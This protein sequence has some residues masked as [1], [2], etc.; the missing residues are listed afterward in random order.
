MKLWSFIRILFE[1]SW[2]VAGRGANAAADVAA[3]WSPQS[4]N[5][6]VGQFARYLVRGGYDSREEV[7]NSVRDYATDGKP[8]SFDAEQIVDAEIAL[9][10][11]DEATWPALTDFDRLQKAIVA[12]EGNGI[13]TRQN[14]TCCQTCGHAEIGEEIERFELAGNH[15][16]GYAFFHQQATESAVDGRDINFAYGTVGDQHSAVEIAK[17]VADS[18]RAAGLRVKWN[19]KDTMCVMVGM[20]W[21][22]RWTGH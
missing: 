22:R 8:Q 6:D 18:M 11:S 13:V 17:E 7:V 2:P 16:R 21:K 5:D 12:L 4:F 14:F 15:A 3:T 9:L 19:G 10:K 20:D 1:K